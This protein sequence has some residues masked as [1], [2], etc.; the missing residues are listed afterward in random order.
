MENRPIGIA[1]ENLSDKVMNVEL[2]KDFFEKGVKYVNGDYLN[3]G[4]SI[5]AGGSLNYQQLVYS[6]KMQPF[7]VDSIC[8]LT[9][10]NSFESNYSNLIIRNGSVKDI[11]LE[12][13]EKDSNGDIIIL[14]SFNC[15]FHIDLFTR[16]DINGLEPKSML[17]IL[18]YPSDKICLK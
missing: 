5:K 11:V 16:I 4:I 13:T 10:G 8:T 6:L 18:F 3:D 2:F 15:Q 9:F 14:P 7:H 1:I 17:V 12:P